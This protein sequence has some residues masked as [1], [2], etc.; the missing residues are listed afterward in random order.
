[1]DPERKGPTVPSGDGGQSPGRD[2]LGRVFEYAARRA[3]VFDAQER[4][5]VLLLDVFGDAEIDD[6]AELSALLV[7][8]PRELLA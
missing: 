2:R 5:F 1:V 7:P 4:L 6:L 8:S 3:V